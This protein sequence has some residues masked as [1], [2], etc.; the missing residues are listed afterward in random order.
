MTYEERIALAQAKMQSF[1][2]KMAAVSEKA[3]A[4]HKLKKEEISAAIDEI[5]ADMEELDA[6]IAEEFSGGMDESINEAVSDIDSTIE[7]N[8]NA[9]EENARLAKERRES[10]AYA[11][12]LQAQMKADALKEK[13]DQKQL[14]R[15]KASM[16]YYILDLLDYAQC[17]QQ[18]AYAA[19]MEADLALLQAAEVASE[20]VELYGEGEI[21]ET[22]EADTEQA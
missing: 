1:K 3:S 8:I 10:K 15:D 7:G 2:E 22:P 6:A 21:E 17:C 13:I 14:E 9:A 11:L 12:K 18:V 19:A 5:Y 20:Y 4:A 16:E